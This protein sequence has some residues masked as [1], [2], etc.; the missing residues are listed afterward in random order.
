MSRFGLITLAGLGPHPREVCQRLAVAVQLHPQTHTYGSNHLY[1]MK[2]HLFFPFALDMPY[3]LIYTVSTA[4][5][6]SYHT[7]NN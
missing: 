6:I 2:A 5:L 4:H 1:D 7:D 3:G